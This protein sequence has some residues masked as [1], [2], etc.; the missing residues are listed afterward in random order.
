MHCRTCGYALWNLGER[1]CPECGSDFLPSQFRF[2][3]NTIRFLC[4]HCNQDYYG[5]DEQGHLSP[6]SFACI[7][8]HAQID[9]D[10]M[11]L[12]PTEGVKEQ[13]TRLARQPWLERGA[14]AGWLGARWF[15][16]ALRAMGSPG[17]LMAVTPPS[18]SPGHA[19]GFAFTTWCVWGILAL[20]PLLLMTVAPL[21]LLGPRRLV[22]GLLVT[23]VLFTL[24]PFI[25]I[26]AWSGITHLLLTLL[27][28][29]A[30]PFRRTV[31]AIAYSSGVNMAAAIPCV[32]A[33]LGPLIW[34][35]WAISATIMIK[36]GQKVP[37]GRAAAAVLTPPVIVFAIITAGVVLGVIPAMQ[38][39][40]TSAQSRISQLQ[41]T[42]AEMHAKDLAQKLQSR[43]Y[44]NIAWPTHVAE[45]VADGQAVPQQF[46]TDGRALAS[47]LSFN[48]ITLESL[49]FLQGQ[50]KADALKQLLA[51]MPADTVAYRVGDYIFTYPELDPSD[52]TGQFWLFIADAPAAT[53]T[54]PGMPPSVPPPPTGAEPAAERTWLIGLS[55]G[56]AKAIAPADFAAAL[57]AQN[58]LRQQAGH[59]PLPSPET[60]DLLTRSNSKSPKPP[61]G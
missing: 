6:R 36:E 1:T 10:D 42:I 55:D 13:H 38:R 18:S 40:M 56:T 7:R 54:T 27:A 46:H 51:G 47:G 53:Q 2:N 57:A 29:P 48:G 8:C 26:L 16:T 37:A 9:M 4:P 15:K 21:A 5:T 41:P 33:Y 52:T 50:K 14:D 31:H 39:M 35:W 25:V 32:G 30:Y 22:G 12:L 28:T 44:A 43:A 58:Q 20:S 61:D 24:F 19:L 17:P 34:V 45:L 11:L 59:T 49:A 60:I 23:I 3:P